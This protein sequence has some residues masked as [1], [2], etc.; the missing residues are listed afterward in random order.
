MIER[1]LRYATIAAALFFIG[2]A[3]TLPVALA[4]PQPSTRVVV[5]S[6]DAAPDG[7]G[8][9]AAFGAPALNDAGQAAFT[10]YLT[11]T[12]GGESDNS[13]IFR[14]D[15]ATVTQIAREGQVAPDGHGTF[16]LFLRLAP[17][18]NDAG[19]V[20]FYGVGI[21]TSGGSGGTVGIFRGSGTT[22]TQIA[23]AGQTAPDGNGSFSTFSVGP[24][25]MPELN[26]AGQAA[27]VSRLTGTSGGVSGA[28]GI[29]RGDGTTLTQIAR[30][31]QAAPDGEGSF[32]GFFGDL[33]LNDAGQAAF[34]GYLT[35]TSGG[36]SDNTGIFRD[37]GATVTQIAR[38]GQ[39]APDG[40]GSFSD[41][42][43][44]LDSLRIR[45]NDSGQV[46]FLNRLTGTSG[47]SSD[48]LGIFRG[49]GATLTQIARTGQT[50]PDGNG[51]FSSLR[52]LSL[53]NAGQAAFLSLLTGTSGGASD[54]EGVFRGD[55]ASV[56]QIARVG[57]VAP[58]G[59]G[60]FSSFGGIFTSISALNDAGQVAFSGTLTGTSGRGIF[61]H[62]DTL[63]LLQVARM[64][65]ELLGS[66][67]THLSFDPNSISLDDSERNGLNELGQVAYG[68]RLADGRRGIAIWT[69]PEPATA[70]LLSTIGLLLV[71]RRQH[72]NYLTRDR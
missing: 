4:V 70:T 30:A 22:L 27:F 14:G 28:I 11:G 56:T 34:S 64:G 48:D 43:G 16:R 5:V 3:A 55:G 57:Q 6:G 60:R 29:F 15:G 13:G 61:L 66:T 67:I 10:G 17:A 33:E 65:D 12:S 39:V 47:G 52:A 68:F 23:R 49:D 1:T 72:G 46:A 37:D 53:N 36:E 2:V 45:L 62:D 24:T 26:D 38:E 7:N 8:S 50:A 35:G 40:N 42:R 54:N 32:G 18:L 19:E 31:G 71:L 58:D 21:D 59:N 25:S 69:I 63:G 44:R 51:S 20:A 9:F 41:F